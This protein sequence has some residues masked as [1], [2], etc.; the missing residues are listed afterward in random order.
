MRSTSRGNSLGYLGS[1]AI[2]MTGSETYFMRS[3]GTIEPLCLRSIRLSPALARS[4]PSNAAMFPASMW[5]TTS[6][7]APMYM[8][9]C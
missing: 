8:E 5:P 9:T 3:N 1:I 6:L 7:K 2:V 4:N